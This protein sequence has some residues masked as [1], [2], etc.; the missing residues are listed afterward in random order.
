MNTQEIRDR[1]RQAPDWLA[2]ELVTRI[3]ILE[4]DLQ[5]LREQMAKLS[6]K[7]KRGRPPKVK[8]GA[9]NVL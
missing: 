3:N 4:H 9:S 8:N 6:E 2:V 7:P 5:E 1:A